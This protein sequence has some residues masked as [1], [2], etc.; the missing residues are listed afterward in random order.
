MSMRPT[1]SLILIAWA[2]LFMGC[3]QRVPMDDVKIRPLLKACSDVDRAALGFSDLP[4]SADVRL[5][6]PSNKY[7]TMLHIY[8]D[9]SRTI[10]FRKSGA[11]YRW[12]GEQEIHK[13]ERDYTSADGTFREEIVITYEIE[14]I[15]GVP[16]NTIFIHYVGDDP[17]LSRS[18]GRLTL[19]DARPILETWR[20]GRANAASVAGNAATASHR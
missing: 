2:A 16:L 10:A 17:I 8:G 9:T 5:E 3:P 18:N 7:D 6:G 14:P 11:G 15:S 12:I 20:K 19:K 13:G 4:S 1:Y